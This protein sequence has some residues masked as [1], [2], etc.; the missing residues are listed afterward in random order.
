[1]NF[2]IITHYLAMVLLL[3]TA[4]MLPHMGFSLYSGE[5]VA[6][7]GFAVSTAITAAA[8][9]LCRCVKYNRDKTVYIKD[10]FVVVAICW[11]A[12]SLTGALPFFFSGEIPFFLDAVFESTSGYTTTG[13]TILRNVEAMSRGMLMWRSFT[14][15]IGGMGVLIFLMAIIPTL[16]GGEHSVSMM[17]AESPGPAPGKLV[18]KLRQSSK[19][20]YSIYIALTLLE[21]V[22]LLFGGM[23]LYDSIVH[24]FATAGTGGFGMKNTSIAY[25]N[26]AYLE[27][28][29]AIFMVLFGINFN[30]YYFLLVRNF[31]GILKNQELRVYLSIIAVST[32]LVTINVATIYSSVQE[33]VRHAFFQTSSLMTSTGFASVNFDLWP[34]F[35]KAILF[36]LMFIGACGGSTG[37]G[38]KVSRI[39]ILFREAKRIL[40]RMVHPRSVEVVKL[41]GKTVDKTVVH[42]VNA[43]L[44]TFMM[45]FFISVVIVAWNGF[46]FESTLSAVIACLNNIGPG[47]G[48]VGPMG[49]FADF[50]VLS[51]IVLTLDMLLGRLEIYP[52]LVLCSP[53]TWKRL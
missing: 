48:V 35:S 23:P 36:T 16:S 12:L 19:I 44:S 7:R 52:I 29:I 30:M 31:S 1:M 20:L 28:V 27:I 10:G 34:T 2:R 45:I 14:H 6:A 47:F 9:I 26:S 40:F 43:Y 38:L 50:S 25:Y 21:I 22:F 24:A 32:V 13:A 17:K 49:G 3:Q 11:I 37:G 39:I 18:P 15:W 4:F 41:D 5:L 8:A 46:D 51:K 42:S 53:R 33:T